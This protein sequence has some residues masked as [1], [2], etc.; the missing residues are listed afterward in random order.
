[1]PEGKR[2]QVVETPATESNTVTIEVKQL[3]RE[4]N[5]RLYW[6]VL[7]GIEEHEY[8]AFEHMVAAV[9]GLHLNNKDRTIVMRLA[10]FAPGVGASD[11]RR[12]TGR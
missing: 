4:G 6:T 8:D 10:T 2:T 7:A 12:M 5:G 9:R 3:R 11:L 1:M